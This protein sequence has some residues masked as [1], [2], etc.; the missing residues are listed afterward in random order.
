MMI[1]TL[2]I[3]KA[4]NRRSI[5]SSTRQINFIFRPEEVSDTRREG[6]VIKTYNPKDVEAT[7]SA[8]NELRGR[9][10][11][12]EIISTLKAIPRL[13]KHLDKINL[14]RAFANFDS[15]TTIPFAS[16]FF[17]GNELNFE[18]AKNL[19][20]ETRAAIV[21]IIKAV[22]VNQF[23]TSSLIIGK[24][25]TEP[26]VGII[27]LE[28]AFSLDKID[29]TTVNC[30]SLLRE[31]SVRDGS[32]DRFNQILSEGGNLWYEKLQN[33]DEERRLE[34]LLDINPDSSLA[35]TNPQETIQRLKTII[36]T[37]REKNYI[38]EEIISSG[39]HTSISVVV[40]HEL[41]ARLI[42]TE[43]AF[44]NLGHDK[45]ILLSVTS[46]FGEETDKLLSIARRS[47]EEER[48]VE[49]GRCG[50]T[51]KSA[52]LIFSHENSPTLKAAM[53]LERAGKLNEHDNAKAALKELESLMPPF[54]EA[55]KMYSASVN[56]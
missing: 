46:V 16:D 50:H 3:Q 17:D 8:L 5:T 56:I 18:L 41:I 22:G 7:Q 2:S 35:T 39:P 28:S 10:I 4:P 37:F 52:L 9:S 13:D 33:P 19:S 1:D 12:R 47:I 20:V 23:P 36:G 54:C 6:L 15:D 30:L 44:E 48:L 11:A 29:I 14:T 45:E 31:I 43:R 24:E 55:I 51:L 53:D 38:P 42:D 25:N 32:I 34:S 21:L 27:D 49:V 40:N 26:E